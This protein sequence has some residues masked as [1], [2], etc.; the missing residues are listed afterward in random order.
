M[1]STIS[2]S[3]FQLHEM[4]PI[5]RCWFLEAATDFA[6]SLKVI[7]VVLLLLMLYL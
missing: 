1:L 5:F 7:R 6:L 3:V 2:S 4:A